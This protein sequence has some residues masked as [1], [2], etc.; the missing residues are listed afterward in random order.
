MA[1]VEDCKLIKLPRIRDARGSLSFAEAPKHVP[2]EFKRIFYL[3]DFPKGTE[4]GG[5]AHHQCHQFLLSI[6][7]GFKVTLD[8]GL[9]KHDFVLNE[10]NVG[11][12]IPPGIWVDL[13]SIVDVSVLVV[14]ASHCY[15]EGD[16][17]RIKSEFYCKV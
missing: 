5:H 1:K 9:K 17:I 2:F 7:G 8:D 15:D 3:Y 12:H 16:Y 11:L 6:V 13:E 4:R 10:P 14:L